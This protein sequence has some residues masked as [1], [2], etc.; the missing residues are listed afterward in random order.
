MSEH[1]AYFKGH[2][3]LV[4]LNE[5]N[6]IRIDTAVVVSAGVRVCVGGWDRPALVVEV[7]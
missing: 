3:I 2:K 5:G 4:S 7:A 6:M 1:T